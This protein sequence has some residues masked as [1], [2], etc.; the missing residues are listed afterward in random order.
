ML[1]IKRIRQAGIVF[2]NVMQ[3]A[4]FLRYDGALSNHCYVTQ[5]GLA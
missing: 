1:K 3:R 2:R 5:E 4:A